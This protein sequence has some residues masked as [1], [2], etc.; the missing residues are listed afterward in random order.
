MSESVS[1]S[2]CPPVCVTYTY[3]QGE[4]HAAPVEL[5]WATRAGDMSH[6][7]WVFIR[8][9]GALG[10]PVRCPDGSGVRVVRSERGCR[11]SV[12][13]ARMHRGQMELLRATSSAVRK[14]GG[15]LPMA[16]WQCCR[17]VAIESWDACW[18]LQNKGRIPERIV[19][20]GCSDWDTGIAG[21]GISLERTNPGAF[22]G[23]TFTLA[24]VARP[25]TRRS[26]GNRNSGPSSGRELV[27]LRA[28][29]DV[30][31]AGVLPTQAFVCTDTFD[32]PGGKRNVFDV[33]LDLCLQE[34]VD[35]RIN[36]PQKHTESVNGHLEHNTPCL[37]ACQ[38]LPWPPIR[39]ARHPQTGEL[40]SCD[41]RRLFMHKVLGSVTARATEVAW[42]KEFADK[43]KQAPPSAIELAQGRHW[44]T[45]S[46]GIACARGELEGRL[47]EAQVLRKAS[48][49]M[50]L[51]ALAAKPEEEI[52]TLSFSEISRLLT[53]VNSAR[54]G[55]SCVTRL[56][57][58][59]AFDIALD[60]VI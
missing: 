8:C 6:S 46:E 15:A 60:S 41:N 33:M 37:V 13:P 48:P 49:H 21:E 45:N 58:K 24:Q 19:M 27:V 7:R 3:D 32:A 20:T 52:A 4:H 25:A 34:P 43:C 5:R 42:M 31:V 29:D 30:P 16:R 50:L 55:S 11:D 17:E 1:V 59:T 54:A 51:R 56:E 53:L 39:I 12:Q 28:E 18:D 2:V 10:T 36:T 38:C 35:G 57:G 47:Q 44:R 9:C 26:S 23:A 14:Y 22:S 40:M